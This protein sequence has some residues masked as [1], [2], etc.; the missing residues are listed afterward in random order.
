FTAAI[1]DPNYFVMDQWQL[2]EMAK[3]ARKGEIV[4]VS[5]GLTP[6]VLERLFVRSAP[7]VEQAV[8]DALKK[9]GPDA[10]LAVIPKGPYVL[11]TVKDPA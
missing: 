3:A 4:V 2:E 5:D 8:A 1:Q 10:K 11:S 7:T 9:H 6:D